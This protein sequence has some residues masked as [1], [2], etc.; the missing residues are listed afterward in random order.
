MTCVIKRTAPFSSFAEH[1]LAK[2]PQ[3]LDISCKEYTQANRTSAANSGCKAVVSS[4]MTWDKQKTSVVVSEGEED[5]RGGRIA[6]LSENK[7]QLL[8]PQPWWESQLAE[9]IHST[10]QSRERMLAP[11]KF[12]SPQLNIRYIP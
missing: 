12:E 1:Q 8:P 7:Y 10:L 3:N 5:S 9:E 11:I 2:M 4:A 6:S